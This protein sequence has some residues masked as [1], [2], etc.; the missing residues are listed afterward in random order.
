MPTADEASVVE[1]CDCP[2]PDHYRTDDGHCDQQSMRSEDP[3]R[4]SGYSW[5]ACCV[6]DCPDVHSEEDPDWLKPVWGT[7]EYAEEFIATLPAEEQAKMRGRAATGE[8]K[9]FPHDEMG[10][11]E[12]RAAIRAEQERLA[13]EK[14]QFSPEG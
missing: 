8:F 6:A 5:C 14:E 9:I 2:R 3:D 13:A 7:A 1:V 11:E 4:L 10:T 12:F